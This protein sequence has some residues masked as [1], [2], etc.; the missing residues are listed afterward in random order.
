MKPLR[1]LVVGLV[2]TFTSALPAIAHASPP[3]PSWVP[4]IYDDAGTPERV[5]RSLCALG[6]PPSAWLATLKAGA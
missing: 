5:A 6:A 4:G 3:D 2:L 1:V